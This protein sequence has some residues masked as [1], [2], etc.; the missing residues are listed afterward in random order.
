MKFKWL[1]LAHPIPLDENSA[2]EDILDTAIRPA[3][4]GRKARGGLVCLKD[5]DIRQGDTRGEDPQGLRRDRLPPRSAKGERSW[6][7]WA[8]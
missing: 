7:M 3:L 8:G 6:Y 5:G 1:P 4:T 2:T